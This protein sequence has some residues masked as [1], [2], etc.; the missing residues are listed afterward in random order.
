MLHLFRNR[1]SVALASDHVTV[2]HTKPGLGQAAVHTELYIGPATRGGVATWEHALTALRQYLQELA[3]PA[4]L[5]IV[6]S[7]EFVRYQLLPA[8]PEVN[9][10]TEELAYVR[11]KFREFYG[12]A[13][14][15]WEFS[16]GPGFRVEPQVVAAVERALMHQLAELCQ[17]FKVSLVSV[18]PYLMALFNHVAKPSIDFMVYE[19]GRICS[20]AVRNG[21]WLWLTTSRAADWDAELPAHIE[22]YYLLK[23][24]SDSEQ[25]LH[26]YTPYPVDARRLPPNRN[27]LPAVLTLETLACGKPGALV[28]NGAV[29]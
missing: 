23:E 24:H 1:L 6:L 4:E 27:I 25:P 28:V 19:S 29:S 18:Q 11:F 26:L 3:R 22:R 20:G 16:W 17:E 21:K 2:S 15:A 14:D 8:Q 5:S 12:D 13:V 7:N 9:G 10:F